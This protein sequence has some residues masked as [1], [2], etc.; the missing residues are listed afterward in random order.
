L[1]VSFIL[2]LLAFFSPLLFFI[3]CFKILIML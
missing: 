1:L 2:S 3:F